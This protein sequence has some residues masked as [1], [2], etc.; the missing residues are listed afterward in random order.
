[1][2]RL[3]TLSILVL[4]TV[5]GLHAQTEV[6]VTDTDLASGQTINWTNDNVYILDGLVYLDSLATLNIE[7]GTVIKGASD[8]TTGDNTSALII[9]RG[10]QIFAE[11]TADEPIIFTAEEDDL[12]DPADFTSADR[13]EWG[14]LIILGRATVATTG[15]IDN[16][17]GI[18]PMETR[19]QFGGN[20]DADNS[21]VLRYVS[22]R[23]GGSVLADGDEINGITFG[24]VGSGTEVDY[25]EV[26]ANDDDGIEFFG[27]TVDVKHATVA[28]CKDDGFDWD[29]GWRG[30]GQFW[31]VIQEP[32]T[33]TGHAGEFDGASPDEFAPASN[34]TIYNATFIGIGNGAT[35]NGGDAAENPVKAILMRDNTAGK[36]YNSV[37]TGYNGVAV[38][39]EDRDDTTIDAYTQFQNGELDFVGNIFSDFQGGTTA[40]DLFIAIDQ[41]ETNVA[42][43]SAEIAAAF[44]TDNTIGVPGIAGISR[45]PDNML[46]PRINAGGIALGGG[47]PSDDPYFT[48]V[49]YRGAFGNSFNWLSGWTALSS[50]NYLGDEVTPINNED[51]IVVRDQDLE[52]GQTYN[53]GGGNCYTLD[54]L[55]YLEA[56]ATLNIAAGTVIRALNA[57]DVTTGDNTSA[58]II[59]RDATINATG[60][61]AEPIIFTAA[62]DDLDDAEDFTAADRGEWGGL[63]ILGNA[64]LATTGGVDN[65]E[66]IDANEARAAF[67]GTDDAD[68]SGVLNYVSIRHGGAVLSDGDEINGLTLGGVGSGTEIDYVEVFANSDDGIEFFGGTVSVSHATV[69]YCGDDGFD[70]DL[71][72]RGTGQYWF[73]IQA[74]N[75]STGHAGEFDGASPDDFA[76]FAKP[77]IYNATFVGIGANSVA[78]GGDAAENPVKAILMRDNTGGE[79]YNSIITDFNGVAVAIEDRTDTDVDA[80]GRLQ[81]GDL[82]FANNF[83][84]SFAAGNT[85]AD[86]FIAIDQSENVVPASSATVAANFLAAGNL[87][88]NPVLNNVLRDGDGNGLD[89]RPNDFGPA[90][91]GAPAPVDTDAFETVSYYGAFA[92]GN[93]RRNRAW[94]DEW[95]A[96]SV[97]EGIDFD[98]TSGVGQVTEG[99]LLLDAPIPNPASNLTRINFELNQASEVELTV[100]D[101]TGRPVGFVTGRY[102]AGEQSE[103]LD[104]SGLANGTYVVV[105]RAAGSRVV[106]KMVVSH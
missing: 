29:L 70:W 24:G 33:T 30:R 77:T 38:A 1:M 75:T 13:G 21:G 95:T 18:D 49:T 87:V 104:V 82:V 8:I 60:T 90:S 96:L 83:F 12:S 80:F 64:T 7:A 6:R 57:N 79:I 92:P 105:L 37:F 41:G 11:G 63:I 43:S 81:A 22:V 78:T 42:S 76:P 94:T 72:W 74:P 56:D 54:G 73:S 106:Q 100:L 58:L 102:G 51:C 16:I 40:A 23:H 99:G 28:F 20:D 85:A 84:H 53:W 2:T 103:T 25:V 98:F 93:G 5:C 3:Y 14:G 39:I 9:T 68:D 19:G 86:V 31:F 71:G 62:E 26:F 88:A 46:D 67:G 36:F 66:G 27:G 45:T 55:V 4:L 91:F 97:A 50:M 89:P 10:S 47:T 61:A 15:G 65:I 32:N 35:A 69:A 59:A 34:P 44:A 52:G 17:E 101:V 48:L